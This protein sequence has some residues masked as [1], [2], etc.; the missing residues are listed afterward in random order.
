M[1]WKQ[2]AKFGT[3]WDT[4]LQGALW[5]YHNTPHAFTCENPFYLL[6]GYDCHSPT[7]AAISHQSVK[8]SAYGGELVLMLS[9]A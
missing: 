1:L 4:Y 2:A 7:E 5:A 9:S 6:F 8:I 3:E